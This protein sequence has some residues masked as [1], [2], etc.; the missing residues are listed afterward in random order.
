VQ[1][2]LVHL[3]GT[4]V[5]PAHALKPGDTISFR[6]DSVDFECEVLLLPPRR[7]PAPAAQACYRESATSVARRERHTENMR[8]AAASGVTTGHRPTR[9][10]RAEL[11]RLRGR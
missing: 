7:G 10:Q 4:R 8:L 1:G 5:K 2:G 11:R 6:R 9:Q 3:N